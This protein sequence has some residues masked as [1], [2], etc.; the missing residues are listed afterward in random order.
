MDNLNAQWAAAVKQHAI[1]PVLGNDGNYYSPIGRK[2]L[3]ALEA[4]WQNTAAYPD[5][6]EMI[7]AGKAV[8]FWS[9]L[10]FG[11]ANIIKYTNRP[12]S[13]VQ[14]M[15]DVLDTN[16]RGSFLETDLLVNLGDLSMKVPLEV[17][18]RL[19]LAWPHKHLLI[20]GNHDLRGSKAPL[21]WSA[22]GALASLAFSLPVTLV[23][24]WVEA[25]HPDEACL[26]DW[27]AL[28]CRLKFG[29][30]H[31]PIPADLL[32]GPDWVCIHGHTHRPGSDRLM[33]N[34]SVEALGFH[35]CTLRELISPSLL[36]DIC[37]NIRVLIEGQCTTA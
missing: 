26:V 21:Q 25:D 23:R 13:C 3:T 17:H 18:H 7:E 31:W 6:G 19:N 5:L 32:P 10:H 14:E 1:T 29:C 28:P 20:A 30:C 9:D 16:L 8:R 35:P 37:Q 22:A 27:T 12:F 11:H 2:T 34:V 15:D 4:V 24:S 33:L 36:L